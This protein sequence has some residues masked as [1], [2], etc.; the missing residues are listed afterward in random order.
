MRP[1]DY[2]GLPVTLQPIE[3][4]QNQIPVGSFSFRSE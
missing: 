4:E 1:Q 3:F 2:F